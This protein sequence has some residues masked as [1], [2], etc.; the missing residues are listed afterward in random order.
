MCVYSMVSDHKYDEWY[1]KF[2]IP[3]PS[4]FVPSPSP[5]VP[6]NPWEIPHAPSIIP[7][8]AIPNGAPTQ[9]EIDEFRRLLERAREYDKQF[10]QCGC[11][12]EQKKNALR[13]LAKILGIDISFIDENEIPKDEGGMYK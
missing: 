12:T 13:E 2:I 10:N 6:V 4:P 1:R 8:G 7:P 11:E 9:D 5:Y 3:P